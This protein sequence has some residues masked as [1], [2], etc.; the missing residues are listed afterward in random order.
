MTGV[1]ESIDVESLESRHWLALTL[2]VL[3]GVIHLYAGITE[4]RLPVLLAGVG[5]LAAVG[6]FL[7]AYRRRL[8]YLL[9]IPYTGIQI[10]LW[11][12]AK[13]GEYT[14]IGYADKVIQVVLVGLFAYL[15]WLEE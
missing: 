6:L 15:Y 14:P 1:T 7:H 10:P 2:V 8:L 11:Y 3:T 9:G 4:G 5:F 12:V 13:S